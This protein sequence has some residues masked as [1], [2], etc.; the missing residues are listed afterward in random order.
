MADESV[1]RTFSENPYPQ[2][3]PVSGDDIT[4]S[5]EQQSLPDKFPQSL[6]EWLVRINQRYLAR[7][8]EN[9][10]P[11][12]YLAA[13]PINEIAWEIQAKNLIKSGG[14]IPGN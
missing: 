4:P 3:K 14:D 7:V 8:Q 1:S 6:I 9:P 2:Q 12:A 11:P 5:Q 13:D 10:T